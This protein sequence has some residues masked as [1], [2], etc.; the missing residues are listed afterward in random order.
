[1]FNGALPD[2]ALTEGGLPLALIRSLSVAALFSVFGTLVF[3]VS[4]APK[5]SERITND[6]AASIDRTLYRLLLASL[7]ADFLA[8]VGWL[9]DEARVLADAETIGATLSAVGAVASDTVFGH[10]LALQLLAV[11]AIAL[12]FGRG[13]SFRRRQIAAAVSACAVLLQAGHSHA[14][15]MEQGRDLLLATQALHLLSGGAWLGGLVPLLLVVRAASPKAGATAA[16]WF[17][18][19]GKLCLYVLVATI[20]VQA[21]EQLG[22]V[23]ATFGSAYGWMALIKAALF[24][25][26]FAFA[27]FNRYR[28]APALLKPEGEAAK[29]AL[30]RSIAMQ[31][32]FALAVV[33]A[34]G[35]IAS[36][37]PAAHVQPIWPFEQRFSLATVEEDT[38]FRD[39][40]IW[41][42][43]ALAGA[44]T[45]VV[46]GI[47][48]RRLRWPALGLAA[49][50]AWLAVPHLDLLFV[51][52]Y[53]TSFYRSPTNFAASSIVDGAALFPQYCAGCHGESGRGD[54]IEAAGLP[55]PPAD[56]TAPHLWA[57]SDGELFWWLSQGMEAPAGGLAMPGFA[58]SLNEDQ[59]W[60]LIDYI[61]AHN[62]GLDHLANQAWTPPVPA[63]ELL[64][65]CA[66]GSRTTMAGLRGKA[67]RIVFADGPLPDL[68]NGNADVV[69]VLVPPGGVD[70]SPTASNCVAQRQAAV[71]IAYGIVSEQPPARLDGMQFLVDPNGW[72]RLQ[73]PVT[74]DATPEDLKLLLDEIQDI[75]R[76]PIAGGTGGGHHHHSG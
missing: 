71:R 43:V 7:V 34:A 65:E 39:E 55:V 44:A 12:A 48:W 60:H 47:L 42:C 1:M 24:G 29:P 41:A 70:T 6:Q 19:L 62:A 35:L 33:I 73:G 13:R 51:Q 32:A 11:P 31:T 17:S 9:I 15:A 21:W 14:L 30:V 20:A 72:L 64:A 36:F 52:A 57:H 56:L 67:V 59:R 26:L 40:V 18:P 38:E 5:V 25:V 74:P 68:P 50:V 58:E 27:W 4:V 66:G 16:R 61:R 76:H 69:T 63:P 37:P 49:L 46:A 3:L 22:S 28:F 54:G 2:F 53:P 23:P 45:L 8:L 75:C 10:L